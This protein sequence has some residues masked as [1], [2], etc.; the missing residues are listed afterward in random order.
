ML[1]KNIIILSIYFTMALGICGQLFAQDPPSE[2]TLEK[3]K[4]LADFD[5]WPG[6]DGAIRAGIDLIAYP[7]IAILDGAQRIHTRPPSF[8]RTK[9]SVLIGRSYTFLFSDA[10]LVVIDIFVAESCAE[11]Q[12]YFIQSLFV[13]SLPFEHR[14]PHRDTTDVIGDIS[15]SSGRH[16]IRNNIFVEQFP[17]G[18]LIP[19]QLILAAQI[20]SI[21]MTRPTATNAAAFRPIIKNFS[22]ERQIVKPGSLTRL[23]FEA[24][25]PLGEG[26]SYKWKVNKG[27][28][29]ER[30]TG[31]YY[32]QGSSEYV[33]M[34]DTLTLYAI[35]EAGFFSSADLHITVSNSSGF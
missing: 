5:N 25:D 22:I 33:E 35:N 30:E 17:R 3:L 19:Q 9:N 14:V 1:Y 15:F 16:F 34:E 27:G 10:D 29:E 21:L 2:E 23:F 20:D 26:L 12:E 11:A 31:E 32:Y 24:I 28:V 13:S 6:K 7:H 4:E 8:R 18:E